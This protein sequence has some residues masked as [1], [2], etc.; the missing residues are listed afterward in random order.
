LPAIELELDTTALR[1][2]L[3]NVAVNAAEAMRDD[4]GK[5]TITAETRGAEVRVELADTGPGIP[6]DIAAKLFQ[7]FTTGKADGTGLGL[8]IARRMLRDLGG[9]L[10]LVRTGPAGTMFR[11]T[12]L[13]ESG[14]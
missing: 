7:P 2:A 5:L 3:G 8:A 13:K 12:F 9:D 10:E 4:G 1:E 14:T 6:D 11:A